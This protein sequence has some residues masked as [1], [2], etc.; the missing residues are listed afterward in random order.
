MTVLKNIKNFILKIDLFYSTK[1]LRYH[2]EPEYRTLFG[3]ITSIILII[4]LVVMFYGK[5]LD[6]INKNNI[7]ATSNSIISVN[8]PKH[9][10]STY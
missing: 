2:S 7:S 10:I 9:T 3:G 4:G 5:V 1:I 6:C 8:P